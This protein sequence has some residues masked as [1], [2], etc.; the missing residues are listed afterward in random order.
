MHDIAIVVVVHLR[1]MLQQS[2][3]Q[4]FEIAKNDQEL[5]F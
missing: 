5:F 2:D 3:N 1:G 4:L